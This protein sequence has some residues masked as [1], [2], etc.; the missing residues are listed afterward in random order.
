[1]SCKCIG[2]PIPRKEHEN[3][4]A[5]LPADVASL[6]KPQQLVFEA[7]YGQVLGLDDDAYRTAGASVRPR[8]EVCD[9]EIICN[10]KPMTSDEYFGSGKTLFGWI[11]AVQG[12]EITELLVKHEMTAIAW[13]EMY[14][15][16]RHSF[17]RNNELSGE[18]A[19]M[20]ALLH[21]G[22]IAYGS[23]VAVI[24]RG[25]VARGAIRMLERLGCCLTVYDRRTSHLLRQEIHRYDIIV[26]AVL[27]DVFREDHL[28]YE[29][30]LGSMKPGGLII[31]ISCD[32]A[33]GIQSSRPTTI[34]SPVYRHGGILH[35]VVDHAPTLFYQTAT[36]SISKVVA[37]FAA[38]L[39]RPESNPVLA[40]ATIVR[41]GRILDDR[42]VRFQGLS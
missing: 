11:H 1:M 3:R 29:T 2:F 9:C 20:H 32:E 25:N 39:E 24:G 33:M 28:V 40:K 16:G 22:R 5:L 13:E 4:R 10:P 26:N 30:D 31:D 27:W 23:Q 7:G 12:R 19:V 38:D 21:W 6:A 42:I 14:Q 35:Y 8:S 18:A 17:W 41:G 37:A 36:E 34:A 15:D